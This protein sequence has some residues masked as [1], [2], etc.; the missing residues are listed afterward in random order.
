MIRPEEIARFLASIRNSVA[1]DLRPDLKSDNNRA[2]ADSMVLV[3]DRLINDL[4]RSELVAN[5]R[6]ATWIRLRRELAALGIESGSSAISQGFLGAYRHLLADTEDLQQVLN[7]EA[8]F[9]RLKERLAAGDK[10]FHHWFSDAVDALV[11]L[12]VASEVHAAEQTAQ[13]S[14]AP[15]PDETKRLH[16]ALSTYLKTRYPELSPEPISQF[17]LAPGGYAKQTGLLTL[18]PNKVLPE[19]L[20]LRLDMAVAITNTSVADEYPVIQRAFDMGLPVPRPVLL[21]TDKAPLGGRFM[22]MTEIENSAPSGP[23]FPEERKATWKVGPDFGKEVAQTIARWHS[24]TKLSSAA[25][26]PDY[27]KAINDTHASWRK[28]A[29][30]PHTLGTEMGFA[31]LLSHPLAANRPWCMVH[32]DFGGHNM[33]VR[34]DHLTG[35]IDWELAH[36]GD[37]AEDLAQCRMML[38]P[39]IMEWKDFVRE[40]VAAGGDPA[41]CDEKS[42]GFFCVWIYLNHLQMNA[43]LREKFLEGQR[44]DI[45]AANVVSHYHALLIEYLARSLRIAVDAERQQ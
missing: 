44:T 24:A 1:G 33:L 36:P 2:K 6:T 12:T 43:A 45:M 15:P 42:V 29:K 37:P 5:E 9:D 38:L 10:R 22:L 17:H 32:G 16:S 8:G 19:K 13:T 31:W 39:G 35:L 40:Y 3:L 11:D 30:G 23:Y 34:G 21:E 20:V 14:A 41:A 28:L 27:Q 25:A 26:I 18:H 7:A 4:T